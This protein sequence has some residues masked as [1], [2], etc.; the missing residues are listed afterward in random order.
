MKVS[1]YRVAGP[2]SEKVFFGRT[3]EE[4]SLIQNISQ[5]DYA[6]FANRKMGKTSLLNKIEPIL[7]RVPRY[8]VFYCDLQA[9]G[10]YESFLDELSETD[11]EFGDEIAKLSEPTPSDFRKTI[12]AIKKSND[13]RQIILI[14]DE[15]DN[16]LKFDLQFN[17]K[18][19]KTFRSLSQRDN[20]RFIFSGTTTLVRRMRHPDSPFFNFCEPIK[21]ASLDENAA[22]QLV[23]VPMR[24]LNIAFENE[25]T[26]VGRILDITA[27]HPNMIQY[28]CSQLIRRINEKQQRTITETDLDLVVAAREFYEFFEYLI[29]GQ[30]TTMERLIVYLM[31]NDPEFTKRNVVAEFEQRGLPTEAIEASLE[32]LC[33]YSILTRK[34]RAYTFTFSEFAKLM[35]AHENIE[36]L[37]ADYQGEILKP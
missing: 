17:E 2:V 24:T 33:I 3:E 35:D 11:S 28:T 20:V 21:V 22:R 7:S 5:S 18:L 13:N 29:W 31:W 8:Q 16:L 19:F 23:T 14:F 6:L 37:A 15:V 12:R 32:I 10:D 9:V 26:I 25:E 1:P 4:K 34:N 36:E 27:C 30:A